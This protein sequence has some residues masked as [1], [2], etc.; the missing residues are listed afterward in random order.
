MNLSSLR[1]MAE[2]FLQDVQEEIYQQ[3]AGHKRKLDISAVHARYPALFSRDSLTFLLEQRAKAQGE[4]RRRLDY[5]GRFLAD[6]YLARGVS[7]LTDEIASREASAVVDWQGETVPFRYLAVMLAQESDPARRKALA[8]LRDKVL[9]QLNPLRAERFV[10]RCALVRELSY[11]SYPALMEDFGG[12]HSAS[13]KALLE[14]LMTETDVAFTELL[15]ETLLD[16]VGLSLDQAQ[17]HDIP[18]LIRALP[19]DRHFPADKA[20]N[21]LHNTLQQMGIHLVEQSNI[22]LDIA[23]RDRKKPGAF[24]LPVHIP[25]KIYFV[26]QPIGGQDDYQALLHEAGHAEHWA[27]INPAQPFEFKRLGDDAVTESF[28]F[29]FEHLTTNRQ[30]LRCHLALDQSDDYLKFAR[31]VRFYKIRRYAARF[32]YALEAYALADPTLLPDRYLSLFGEILAVQPSPEMYLKDLDDQLYAVCYLRAWMFE[33]QLKARL[34][35]QAGEHWFQAREGGE[36]LRQL[37]QWGQRYGVAELARQL[38]DDGLDS[39]A[40]RTELLPD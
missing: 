20:L 21:C 31:L 4:E 5:L 33:P 6:G 11:D 16:I 36:I 34:R 3:V 10:R 23:P 12:P 27:H 7:Q 32:F 1:E 8:L 14:G 29:L 9:S 37:W 28:A 40:L 30:W 18:R 19:F 25:D 24:A 35:D 26:V 15:E 13:L 39:Q 2:D 38:G 22:I 17:A